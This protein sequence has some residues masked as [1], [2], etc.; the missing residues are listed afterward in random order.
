M[1]KIKTLPSDL[2]AQE[3][4]QLQILLK[5]AEDGDQ[6]V[7]PELRQALDDHPVIWQHYGDL[8]LRAQTIWVIQA[9]GSD[10]LLVE[11][12]ERKLDE[13]RAQLAGPSAPALEQLLADRIALCWLHLHHAEL[14]CAGLASRPDLAAREAAQKRLS[15]AQHRYLTAVKALATV[16]KLLQKAP[17]P[18]ELVGHFVPRRKGAGPGRRDFP[19]PAAAGVEN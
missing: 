14:V 15:A 6:A 7:L 13:L 17:T 2:P 16:R 9:S 4:E 1:S 12:L 5:R 3:L 18:L 11:S 19:C 8:A 10:V